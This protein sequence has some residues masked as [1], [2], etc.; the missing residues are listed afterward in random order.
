M[1]RVVWLH[2]AALWAVAVA[3]P[4][5]DLLGGNPEFFVAHRAGA[6]EVLLVTA[7][8]AVVFPAA[9]AA[10]VTLVGLGGPRART[11]AL[12]V[13]IATFAGLFSVQVAIR[14]GAATWPVAASVALAAG[15][16]T[17]AAYHRLAA[18][19]TFFTVLSAA[20]IIVPVVFLTRPGIRSLIAPRAEASEATVGDPAAA[21]ATN[22]I[23]VTTPVVLVIFDELPLVSLLDGERNIDPLLYPNFAALARDGVWYRNATTVNDFTRWA[24]P[25]IASG[26]FPRQAALPAAID[27][28]DSVFTLL[29]HTHRLEVT[30]SVTSL[31]PRTLCATGAEGSPA[32]R[33]AAIG[34]DLRVVFLHTILPDDLAASLPDPT[35]TWAGFDDDLQ[36]SSADVMDDPGTSADAQVASGRD[37]DAD[38]ERAIVQAAREQWREGITA[39]RVAPVRE[40]IEGIG[41]DDAQP[42]FYFLH[43]LVS[44]HPY[45]MLPGGRQNRTWVTI[46]GK[47]GGSWDRRQDWAV[48][49]QYQ[50]HLLQAGFIDGLLGDL[51]ARLRDIDLYDR[52]LIIVTAD[53][54]IAHVPGVSQRNFLGENAAEILRVPLVIK[55]P[56]RVRSARRVSDVNAETIDIVPTIADVLSVELTW[57]VDGSSLLDPARPE[58][59]TKVVFSGGTGRRRDL[60]A[61]GPDVG[62]ALRRKLALFGDGAR[63]VHRA[64]RLPP[65]D[66]LIGRRVDDLQVAGGGGA[67]EITYAWEYDDVNPNDEEAVVFD[68]AGRFAE[69]RPDAVVAL[70]VN[71]VVEAVTRTWEANPRGWL[72]T[73]RFDAWRPGKNALDVFVVERSGDG[74][75]LRRTS[76][77]QVRPP[78]L[79]L[80]SDAAASDWGVGQWGFYPLE[81]PAGGTSFRWT[82]D[83]AELSNLFTHE[84]PREVDVAVAMVPGGRPKVLKIEANDCT[85]FEGEVGR[86]WSATLPLD[87]CAAAGD[88]LTLRFTTDAPRGTRDRRRLGVAVSRVVLR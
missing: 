33:L 30:E 80:I 27:H 64:P 9:V 39:D 44:H 18:V 45:Y 50:R 42:T 21:R 84:A 81:E 1:R 22:G 66:A 5:F 38:E 7:A 71:G 55:Y 73:P 76:V 31:C 11:A 14:A 70:A 72:A 16:G 36:G 79:N 75:V 52:A 86:G 68:V 26:R 15:I 41:S 74:V 40:F 59:P 37:D 58:R 53:H 54:G 48:A 57:P 35:G 12:S 67:V 46:P 83:R 17:A 6:P 56:E 62:P 88:G 34:R 82:R 47:V 23:A 43:T 29:R 63:N 51:V 65:Y 85:L 87:R 28:P 8:L 61:G 3:Q 2:L 24:V 49:Q 4:L 77:G 25:S 10:C 78:D 20:A 60:D 13:T 19:R 69:V 32:D